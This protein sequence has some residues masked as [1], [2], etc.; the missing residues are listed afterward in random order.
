MSLKAFGIHF[1]HFKCRLGHILAE[2][3]TQ[4]SP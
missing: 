2:T 1:D 4:K 3:R